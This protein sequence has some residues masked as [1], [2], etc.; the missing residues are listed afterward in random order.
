MKSYLLSFLVVEREIEPIVIKN[1]NQFVSL[2][3]GDDQLLDV[4]NFLG[5]ATSHIFFAET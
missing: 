5:G 1:A 2:K 4:M 3:V